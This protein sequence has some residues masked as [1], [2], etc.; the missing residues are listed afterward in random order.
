M[1]SQ[2]H[3][4]RDLGMVDGKATELDITIRDRDFT[5]KQSPG[6]LQSNR[7]GGTTGAAVWECSVRFAEWLGSTKNT[8]FSRGILGSESHVLELGAGI[9]GFVPL[10]LEPRIKQVVATDQQYALNL[11]KENVEVNTRSRTKPRKGAPPSTNVKVI[12]LDWE[13]DDFESTFHSHRLDTAFDAVMA[14][15]CVFNYAL[16]QPFVQACTEVCK[17]GRQSEDENA[18]A[19]G[20]T[21]CLVAQQLRQPDVFQQWLEAF[22]KVFRVWRV[23]DEMLTERLR[24]GSGFVVHFAALR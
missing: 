18:T 13:K 20:Q 8:L 16:I 1:F 21:I 12:A 2:S 23:P 5:I 22:S 4:S 7:E 11:L 9:S 10:M 6:V 3:S 19:T 17:H 15:D 24:E 14:C